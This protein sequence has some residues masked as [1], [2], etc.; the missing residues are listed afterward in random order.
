MTAKA[1]LDRNP[2][3]SE[4]QIR[5]ALDPILYRCG[6]HV[7]V[8]RAVQRAAGADDRVSRAHTGADLVFGRCLV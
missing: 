5:D 1:L 2:S 3:P 8:M 6:S 7:R 4:G